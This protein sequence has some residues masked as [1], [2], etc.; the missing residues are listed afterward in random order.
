[1][2]SQSEERLDGPLRVKYTRYG[3]DVIV[4]QLGGELDL[5]TTADAWRVIESA[6]DEPKAMLVIDLTELEFLGVKGVSFL[7]GLAAARADKDTLRLLPS[8]HEGV[9]RVLQLTGVGSAIPI[10]AH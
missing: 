8:V 4:F 5:A 2:L 3:D 6:L 10:V 7:Y 1:M 9:N